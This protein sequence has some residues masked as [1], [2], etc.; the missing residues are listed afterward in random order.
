MIV[1][2]SSVHQKLCLLPAFNDA[3]V[4]AF[5]KNERVSLQ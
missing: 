2:D 4:A 1:N 3:A 5:L